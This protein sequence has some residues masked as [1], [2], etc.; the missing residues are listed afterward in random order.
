MNNKSFAQQLFEYPSYLSHIHIA[1]NHY[2]KIRDN[3]N[4]IFIH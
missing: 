4:M 1:Q 2:I 3:G